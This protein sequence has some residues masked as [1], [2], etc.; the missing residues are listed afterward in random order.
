MN[1]VGVVLTLCEAHRQHHNKIQRKVDRK[2]RS[3]AR[4]L[5][6]IAKAK[7]TTTTSRHAIVYILN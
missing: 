5:K 1:K 7:M 2:K 4:G 3:R 6:H